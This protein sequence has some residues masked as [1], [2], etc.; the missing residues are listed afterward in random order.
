MRSVVVVEALP[1]RKLL[2]EIDIVLVGQEWIE[3]VLVGSMRAL[4]FSI[5]RWR[6]WLDDEVDGVGLGVALV[7]L[8]C[9]NACGVIDR[10]VRVAS[11]WSVASAAAAPSP[12]YASPSPGA[13]KLA[14]LPIVPSKVQ[15]STTAQTRIKLVS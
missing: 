15:S 8:Q 9:P 14:R 5:A 4:D 2:L 10:R 13:G 1:D 11:H 6:P 3:L 12:R 7:D